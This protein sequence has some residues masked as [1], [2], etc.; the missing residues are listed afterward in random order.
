MTN[1]VTI[2]CVIT[3]SLIKLQST[4]ICFAHEN[5]IIGNIYSR[6]ML[7]I[8]H[9]WL[10]KEE[11]EFTSI[12]KLCHGSILSLN[13]GSSNNILFFTLSCYQIVSNKNAIINSRTTIN[14]NTSPISIIIFHNI[15]MKWR[16]II[17]PFTWSSFKYCKI[18]Q[19]VVQWSYT[20]CI[21]QLNT[22]ITKII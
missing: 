5:M 22:P 11:I 21:Y 7:T 1:E 8:H 10:V 3:M 13:I 12:H 20:D 16:T 6:L 9:Y 14:R 4:S 2:R 18:R 15:Q 19:A 17:Q